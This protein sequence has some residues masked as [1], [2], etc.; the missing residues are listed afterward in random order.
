MQQILNKQECTAADRDIFSKHIPAETVSTGACA[1]R[2]EEAVKKGF[3]I[4]S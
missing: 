2:A 4:E 3:E 1:G